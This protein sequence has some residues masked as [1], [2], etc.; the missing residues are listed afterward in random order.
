[1]TATFV[2]S[3][4]F[5]GTMAV[6]LLASVCTAVEFAGGTGE[7]ND[8]YQIATAEQLRSIGSVATLLDKHYILVHDIDL[9]PGLPGG[10]VFSRAVIAPTVDVIEPNTVF[11]G[12]VFSGVFDGD[13]HTISNLTIRG[14][15]YLGLVGRICGSIKNVGLVN[16]AIVGSGHCV[17]GL[18]GYNEGT[19]VQCYSVGAVD[20]QDYVGG[21]IGAATGVATQ[22]HC[23]GAVTGNQRVGG[24]VGYSKGSIVVSHSTG[25]VDGN[26]SVGGLVGFNYGG[27]TAS[28]STGAVTGTGDYAAGLAGTNRG[29]VVASY[30]TG[31]VAGGRDYVGGL[32]GVNGGC[33]AASYSTGAVVGRRYVGGLV[34]SGGNIGTSYS[35]GTVHGVGDDVGGLVGV[36]GTGIT[37][38]FWNTETSGMATS[39]GGTG[40]TTGEMQSIGTLL[41]GGWDLVDETLNGACDYWQISPGEYPRLCYCGGNGPVMP[42]GSGTAG[43]PYLI[44]D[45]RDLGAVWF[46]PT[47]SYRLEASVDLSGI[48]WS[49]AVAPWFDGT[50]DGNGHVVNN[51]CIQ[52]SAY[53][54][55]LGISGSKATISKLGLEVANVAGAG[56]Y[57]GG[58][59]GRNYGSIAASYSRGAIF[60]SRGYVGG[61]V[62]ENCGN[63]ATSYTRGTVGRTETNRFVGGLVGYNGEGHITT[64]YSVCAVA[65][66]DYIG[67]LVGGG[68]SS[69]VTAGFW[70]METSGLT[71]SMGGTAK[72]SAEMQTAA[73]FL[74]A[75]WDLTETWTICEGVDYPRLQWEGLECEDGQ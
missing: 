54:G 8:P 6:C 38:S 65:G 15:N 40:K 46:K 9:A 32:V 7:S 57:V 64:S 56:D 16:V 27:I 66:Y 37:A 12:T 48:I 30:S 33:V 44:R 25:I 73:T 68:S 55:L 53:L 17:G 43:E 74:D 22:C 61:L 63:I 52:G 14:V 58:L 41:T 59:V 67:G 72:T 4:W 1:M 23:D 34:G 36:G 39:N 10:K 75:G 42:E 3:K 35:T 47:A 45:A 5:V 20:G 70:D 49:T 71:S 69:R 13:G 19:I 31:A 11:Q 60:A 21:L 50:F 51:L 2:T 24:L 18:A 26:W 28:Y 29:S 62:G